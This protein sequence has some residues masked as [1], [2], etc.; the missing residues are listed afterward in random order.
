MLGDTDG[1]LTVDAAR[2]YAQHIPIRVIADT[3]TCA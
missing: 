2:D 1:R 3:A